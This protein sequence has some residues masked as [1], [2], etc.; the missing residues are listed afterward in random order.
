MIRSLKLLTKATS[1]VGKVGPPILVFD[2][3]L[4]SPGVKV[5]P[6]TLVLD[7]LPQ[8]KTLPFYAADNVLTLSTIAK[9]PNNIFKDFRYLALLAPIP[10]GKK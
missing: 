7:N 2:T 8:V 6:F 1:D 3:L 9:M 4:I 10:S 5:F